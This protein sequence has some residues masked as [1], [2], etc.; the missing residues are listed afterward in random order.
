MKLGAMIVGVRGATASTLIATAM[1]PREGDAARYLVSQELDVPPVDSIQWGGWDVRD[2]TWEE[3][4]RRHGVLGEDAA[5]RLERVHVYDAVAFERDHAVVA[6]ETKPAV[7]RGPAIVAR[8]RDDIRAFRAATG[9]DRVVVVHLSTPA[10]L[11]ERDAWPQTAEAFLEAIDRT[12]FA[13]APPYYTAAAIEEGA[14]VVDY[15]ASPTLE[16]PG[17]VALA[18]ARGVPLAGRD[19]STG[20]TLLKSVLAQMFKTRRLRVRGWYSTN[21]LGNHDGLVLSDDRFADTKRIDKTALLEE[22][23]GEPVEAHLV[24]IRHYGP[25]GDVKEAWDAVDFEGWGGLAGTLRINWRACDSLL[26][27][28][29]ILDLVR[30]TARAAEQ[31]RAGLQVQLSSF[32]KYPLG[33][34]ERRY[35]EL[36]KWLI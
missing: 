16:I 10:I 35:L 4:V 22:I 20:Q 6:D 5:E 32:F 29:A 36:A 14:A 26:A 24:D 17:L 28:P 23:L 3:T 9:V 11:P 13:T 1:A 30:L 25:A 8:L 33:T 2:E 15:T 21:I 34:S 18:E 7:E 31:G 19:G 12:A 27:T